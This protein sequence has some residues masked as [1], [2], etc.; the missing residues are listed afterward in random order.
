M[1]KN[2]TFHYTNEDMVKDLLSITPID[3]TDSVLDAGS[4]KNKVWYNNLR[5]SEKY[6]CELEDGVNFFTDWNKP[7]DWII[8]NPPFAEGALFTLKASEFA[9][10]GIAFL[11]NINFLNSLCLPTRLE[12]LKNN[13]F[14]IK[15]LHVISDKRWFGRYFYIVFTKDSNNLISWNTKTYK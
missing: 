5:N 3:I 10:K 14:T 12:K 7:V 2:I 8:G 1:I 13:G 9:R 15:S 6:E 4:G 11:G